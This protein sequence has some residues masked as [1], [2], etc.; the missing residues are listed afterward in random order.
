[1][2]QLTDGL[3]DVLAKSTGVVKPGDSVDSQH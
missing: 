1:M 2:V 3:H